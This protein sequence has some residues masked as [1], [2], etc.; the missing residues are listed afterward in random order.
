MIDK[1]AEVSGEFQAKIIKVRDL[2]GLRVSNFV[3][4]PAS[5]TPGNVAVCLSGGGSRAMTAGMG[6]LL[7][8]KNLTTGNGQSLLGKTKAISTVSGGS[9]VGTTFEYLT[10]PEISDDDYL[11]TYTPPRA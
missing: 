9:W 3:R 6:Q 2:S 8:L 11:G 10:D 1:K 5:D 4:R 7:A